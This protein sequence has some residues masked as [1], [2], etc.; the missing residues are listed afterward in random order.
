MNTGGSPAPHDLHAEVLDIP[1]RDGDGIGDVDREVFEGQAWH[2]GWCI[3]VPESR[4]YHGPVTGRRTFLETLLAAGALPLLRA[5]GCRPRP[6][7]PGGSPPALTYARP[8]RQWVEALPL[9][10]GRLGAMVFGGIGVERLQLNEDSLWS[11][12]PVGL[13]Q[14]DGPCECCPRSAPWW[15]QAA[16]PRPTRRP[17]G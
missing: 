7:A 9:G 10:N 4:H 5:R 16:L 3:T 1:R 2:A 12:G 11:G 17:N 14:P 13:E 8:A 15:P 6:S